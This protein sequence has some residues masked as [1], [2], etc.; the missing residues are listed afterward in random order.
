LGINIQPV[1]WWRTHIGSTWLDTSIERSAGSR[2]VSGGASEMNDPRYL[3]GFR[4]SINLPRD[5]EL[6]VVLRAVD[7]LPNPA[8]PAYAEMNLRLGWRVTPRSDVWIVGHDLLHGHHPE[9][10]ATT[11]RRVEFERGFRVGS[12]LRF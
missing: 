10:G 1:G 6:D 8:V 2:D 12:T 7:D 4:S 3:F 11:P 9:L 5:V